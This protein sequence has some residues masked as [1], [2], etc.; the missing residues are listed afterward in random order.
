MKLVDYI[1]LA[2]ILLLAL[3]AVLRARKLSKNACGSC[4]GCP[5]SK[6]CSKKPEAKGPPV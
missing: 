3:R 4:E 6:D 5:Q 2:L 1:A